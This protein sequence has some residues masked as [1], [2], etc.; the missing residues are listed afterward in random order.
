MA[1]NRAFVTEE[2]VMVSFNTL[3]CVKD[4][5]GQLREMFLLPWSSV[6]N[7]SVQT[8]VMCLLTGGR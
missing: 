2:N 5:S 4:I 6:V 8:A 7:H 1:F 3:Q